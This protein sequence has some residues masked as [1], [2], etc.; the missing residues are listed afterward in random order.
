M[1]RSRKQVIAELKKTLLERRE[2]IRRA[3]AGDLSSLQALN[4]KMGDSADWAAESTSTELNSQLAEVESRELAQIDN[5]LARM[6]AGIYGI[7]EV[8]GNE[9]PLPR[10]EA[11]PYATTTIEAQRDLESGKAKRGHTP[12]WSRMIDSPGDDP[13][14]SIN[15]IELA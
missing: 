12:D 9:I 13:T 15:D 6:E 4:D 14:I 3:L 11:L 1:A 10:L 2:A 7:C 5:A 8:S